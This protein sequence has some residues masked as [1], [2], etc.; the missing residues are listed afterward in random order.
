[1]IKRS[2][3]EGDITFLN[4]CAPKTGPQNTLIKADKAERRNRK[5]PQL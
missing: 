5:N 4:M 3:Y 1:M 2:I